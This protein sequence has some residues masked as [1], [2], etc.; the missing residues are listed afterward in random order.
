L[1]SQ[2]LRLLDPPVQVIGQKLVLEGHGL[3]GV[4]AGGGTACGL[5]HL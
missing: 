4:A 3:A 1:R 5:R 2:G